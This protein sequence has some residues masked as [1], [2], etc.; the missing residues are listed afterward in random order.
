[1]TS[2][3]MTLE[4]LHVPSAVCRTSAGKGQCGEVQESFPSPGAPILAGRCLGRAGP[5]S[6]D[7]PRHG[8]W[9]TCWCCPRLSA[10]P[11]HPAKAVRNGREEAALP[12][13]GRPSLGQAVEG[14]GRSERPSV[15]AGH[16]GVGMEGEEKPRALQGQAQ[17]GA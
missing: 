9:G 15:G 17:T 16:D 5:G 7:C 11:L 4:K 2:L 6:V 13:L 12:M 8:D 10:K 1:M 3:E 14:P